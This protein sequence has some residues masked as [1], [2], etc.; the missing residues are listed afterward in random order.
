MERQQPLDFPRHPYDVPASHLNAEF[1]DM[2]EEVGRTSY[3][4]SLDALTK[5]PLKDRPPIDRTRFQRIFHAIAEQRH[6]SISHYDLQYVWSIFD[7]EFI[8]TF[9]HV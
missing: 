4:D 6:T 2:L 7:D 3:I 8:K 5:N 1:F 9:K